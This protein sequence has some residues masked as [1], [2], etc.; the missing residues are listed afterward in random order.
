M[1]RFYSH[2]R[3]CSTGTRKADT[4]TCPTCREAFCPRHIFSYVDESNAA[5]TRS[6]RC[7]CRDCYATRNKPDVPTAERL[8]H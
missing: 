6:S 4:F 5:I 7:Y 3:E 8:N 1:K 2:C